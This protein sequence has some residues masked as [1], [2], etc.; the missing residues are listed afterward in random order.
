VV[1][2]A[3]VMKAYWNLPDETA[4]VL[5]EGPWPGEK[6][7]YTGDLF[8]MDE[9]GYL[10]FLGR[11]DDIIKTG[12]ERVSPKEVEDALYKMDG[13]LEA[14][15]VG[16]DDELLGQAIKAVVVPRQASALAEKDVIRHCAEHLESFMVPKYVEFRE[17]LPQTSTGKV[18]RADLG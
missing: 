11:R 16:V 1:R 7:L 5:R 6:V 18:R 9:D 14:T 2:G 13:I 10:Y 17:E 8:E 3:N 4:E 15:V 12:G